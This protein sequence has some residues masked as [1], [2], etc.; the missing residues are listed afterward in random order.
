M[1]NNNNAITDGE[2]PVSSSLKQQSNK[3]KKLPPRNVSEQRQAKL[4]DS[5]QYHSV[6]PL[7][8]DVSDEQEPYRGGPRRPSVNPQTRYEQY[9]RTNSNDSDK[10]YYPPQPQP[11]D[12][13][14][15]PLLNS[16]IRKSYSY[17]QSLNENVGMKNVSRRSS[18]EMLTKSPEAM[19]PSIPVPTVSPKQPLNNLHRS[20]SH[21]TEGYMSSPVSPSSQAILPPRSPNI[22]LNHSR[23]RSPSG[24]LRINNHMPIPI[25]NNNINNNL[26]KSLPNNSLSTSNTSINNSST[27][28]NNI[29]NGI[30]Y[31]SELSAYELITVKHMA[32]STLKENLDN[33][34]SLD[35]SSLIEDRKLKLWEKVFVSFKANQKKTKPK[36]YYL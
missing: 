15:N 32:I 14:N 10:Y 8:E 13:S 31:Y 1:E 5:M 17:D 35:L 23:S 9:H 34:I 36:G 19:K 24:N 33:S 25:N 27:T 30:R 12:P 16:P 11:M 20:H 6:E 26:S 22:R 28:L 4:E 18:R 3:L 7:H 21:G 2:E 29:D